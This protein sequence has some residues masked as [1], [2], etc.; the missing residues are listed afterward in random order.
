MS[1][2]AGS[3]GIRIFYGDR[4]RLLYRVTVCIISYVGK[5]ILGTA[6]RHARLIARV[7]VTAV[8]IQRQR[9]V[10][11]T[12]TAL[13]LYRRN[14][15]VRIRAPAVSSG[16]IV[17]QNIAAHALSLF[18]KTV[19]VIIGHGTVVVHFHSQRTTFRIARGVRHTDG[20]AA[21]QLV[22]MVVAGAGGSM[23]LVAA[24]RVAVVHRPAVFSLRRAGHR[25]G[26]AVHRHHAARHIGAVAGDGH[27]PAVF[28]AHG[29]HAVFAVQLHRK[30][31]AARCTV[32]RM[33]LGTAVKRAFVH[34]DV[35]V[36]GIRL[37]DVYRRNIAVA[38]DRDRQIGSGTV[39]VTILD[40][41]AEADTCRLTTGQTRVR[42]GRKHIAAVGIQ[43]GNT[44]LRIYRVHA[45]RYRIG[46]VRA[47]FLVRIAAQIP[48]HTGTA[49]GTE[50]VRLARA[51]NI[52]K[53]IA[54]GA[55]ILRHAV[56]V[57]I[58]H[59]HVVGDLDTDHSRAAVAVAVRHH[60]FHFVG[61]GIVFAATLLA[62]FLG[63]LVQ[64]IG[65]GQVRAVKAGHVQ[66]PLIRLDGIARQGAVL[67]DDDAADGDGRHAVRGGDAHAA[68]GRRGAPAA[69]AIQGGFVHLEHIVRHGRREIFSLDGD[70]RI[71]RIRAGSG[72]RHGHAVVVLII[73]ARLHRI[74]GQLHAAVEAD[75]Q[76]PQM[77]EAVQQVAAAVF[78]VAAAARGA[79]AGS[80]AGGGHQVF[81]KGREEILAADLHTF[82]LERRHLFLGI[83]GVEILQLNGSAIL[84]SQDEVVAAAGQRRGIRRKIKDE[85]PVR[86]AGDG[87]R[88][89]SSRLGKTDIG[90][91]GPPEKKWYLSKNR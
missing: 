7:R 78:V 50:T 69:A 14:I 10:R 15:A 74:C 72:R 12:V 60:H 1:V 58:G 8:R 67:P 82:H 89:T 63:G 42:L 36:A 24:E 65:I 88:G 49:V 41:I 3:R 79:A 46:T 48:G 91:E 20:D 75:V 26:N 45:V 19:Y 44:V 68:V 54:T 64:R 34:H 29:D 80:G 25:H 71:I 35:G 13:Q 53:D 85:A 76:T 62:V 9:T 28:T 90:H 37:S 6:I 81:T 23:L 47:A 66:V 73:R 61:D 56:H 83:R 27:L 52:R 21:R 30:R 84:E 32:F 22:R 39:A 5:P 70:V 86:S 38:I 31:S 87:L 16:F 59:G 33:L 77:V 57:V 40:R 43:R 4:Q 18:G 55:G 51:V 11:A 2:A 17:F